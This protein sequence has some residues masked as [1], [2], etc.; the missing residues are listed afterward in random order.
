MEVNCLG[1]MLEA[2]YSVPVLL[3]AEPAETGPS[4]HAM[5]WQY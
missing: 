2:V 4:T 1:S 3:V 5:P